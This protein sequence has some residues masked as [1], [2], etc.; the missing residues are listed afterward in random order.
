[1]FPQA[2]VHLAN[3]TKLVITAH[4]ANTDNIYVQ[5]VDDA[6]TPIEILLLRDTLTPSA[7]H[8]CMCGGLF[9]V[10]VNGRPWSSP[11]IDHAQLVSSG[12]NGT[13][14]LEFWMGATPSVFRT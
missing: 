5:N 9:Q 8:A 12:S 7:V 2:V 14:T 6:R 4:N 13:T 3:D 11:F 10:A 1:V